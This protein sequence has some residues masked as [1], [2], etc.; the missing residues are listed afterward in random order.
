MV[1]GLVILFLGLMLGPVGAAELEV[2]V[3]HL[4]LS[5][6]AEGELH[7][8]EQYLLLN[9]GE[10]FFQKD[11][12]SFFLP[13]EAK[14]IHFDSSVDESQIEITEDQVIF[15][16]E[17]PEGET[18]LSY[19][20]LLPPQGDGLDF[21]W[22]REFSFDTPSFFVMSGAGELQVAS[23]YLEDQGI[24]AMGERAL[25]I[26]GGSFQQG[27]SLGLKIFPDL[28]PAPATGPGIIDRT[29]APKFHHPGHIRL[30]EQS[31]FGGIDAHLFIALVIGLP[32]AGLGVYFW[33]RRQ[34]KTGTSLLEQEEE[35]FQRYLIRER[36]LLKKLQELEEEKAAGKLDEE[37]Y[38]THLDLYKK[39][40]LEVRIKLK[41]FIE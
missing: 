25:H 32:I 23:E 6:T 36:F 31:P 3:N 15:Q 20:Y 24:V 5:L 30:W 8:T 22:E 34:E 29:T 18:T 21:F 33:K 13:A 16:Q 39:R 27:E 41:D 10:A 40:L 19:H 28:N 35:V 9:P 26:Y 14:D 17:I 2:Q 38:Q 7:V 37:D 12:L 11:L 4:N 1:L